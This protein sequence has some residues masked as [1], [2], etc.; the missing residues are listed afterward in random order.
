MLVVDGQGGGR[1]CQPL[2]KLSAGNAQS[3]SV[4]AGRGPLVLGWHGGGEPGSE[5]VFC[6]LVISRN[7]GLGRPTRL[8]Y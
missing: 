4:P 7:L 8:R 5:R 1:E 6:G 2:R 3:S